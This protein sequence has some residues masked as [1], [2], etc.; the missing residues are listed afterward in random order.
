MERT[1]TEDHSLDRCGRSVPLREYAL[2]LKGKRAVCYQTATLLHR[3][4]RRLRDLVRCLSAFG[5]KQTS[6]ELT[7]WVGPTRLTHSR[8]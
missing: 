3:G 2:K 5:A 8:H 1:F 7:G 4:V 6:G